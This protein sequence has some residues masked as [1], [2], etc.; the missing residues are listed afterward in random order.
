[1]AYGG[2]GLGAGEEEILDPF[3][4]VPLP[5]GVKVYFLI[6]AINPITLMQNAIF[7]GEGMY[8]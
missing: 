4:D 5:K 8:L 2:T 6:P 7:L 1:M 3:L